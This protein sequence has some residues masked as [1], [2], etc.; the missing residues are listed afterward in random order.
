M[1]F[2]FN[3]QADEFFF[4]YYLCFFLFFC[5]VF[6]REG[7]SSFWAVFL[8]GL[9]ANVGKCDYQNGFINH[10]INTQHMSD[11]KNIKLQKSSFFYFPARLS[12]PFVRWS[13]ALRLFCLDICCYFAHFQS[14]PYLYRNVAFANTLKRHLT[15]GM[16]Q[17]CV[18]T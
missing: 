15:R 7:K 8:S 13:W 17:W 16:N 9:L 4:Q 18:C 10:R 11:V 6:N 5:F 2:T 1:C 3:L 14:S 12:F